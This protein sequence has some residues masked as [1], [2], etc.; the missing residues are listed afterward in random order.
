MKITLIA[1]LVL[2]TMVEAQANNCLQGKLPFFQN[3]N[4]YQGGA[5]R[6]SHALQNACRE[7]NKTGFHDANTLGERLGYSV[8]STVSFGLLGAAAASFSTLQGSEAGRQYMAILNNI[9]NIPNPIERIKRVYEL[10]VLHSGEYDESGNGMPTW[11]SGFFVGAN[12]PE[13]LLANSRRRGTVGVCREFASLLKWSLQQVSRHPT[14]TNGALAPTDFSSTMIA[15]SLPGAE[16]WDTPVQH[17]WV[18]INVPVH[19]N[20]R[21]VDFTHFDLDTTWYPQFTPLFPRRSGLSVANQ[22][23]AKRECREIIEC[24]RTF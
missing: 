8:V 4:R 14:S 1:W 5:I 17:A 20:G 18:R 12:R 24:M 19:E 7:I 3:Y 16:G 15:G 21:L 2:I 11:I 9:R 6:K 23:R 10:A 13:N 22:N